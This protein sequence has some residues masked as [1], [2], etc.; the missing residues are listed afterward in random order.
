MIEYR[1]EW[2]DGAAHYA[3]QHHLIHPYN[4]WKSYFRRLTDYLSHHNGNRLEKKVLPACD[5]I[6]VISREMI[7]HFIERIPELDEDKFIYLPNGISDNE[8]TEL[9]RLRGEKKI[10]R[11]KTLRVLY[12]GTLFGSQDIR[13]FLNALDELLDDGIMARD[14]FEVEV[15]GEINPTGERWPERLKKL[16]R[17]RRSVP[18]NTVYREYFNHDLLLFIIGDWPKSDITMTGKIFELIESRQPILA[19]LP[20]N[21]NGCARRLLEK[22]NAAIMAD[23]NNRENIKQALLFL[24]DQ[25]KNNREIRAERRQMDWFYQEHHY[26]NI[27]RRLS[28]TC[29]QNGIDNF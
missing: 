14:D 12:A 3:A 23:I 20:M 26:K 27:Y 22:S 21:K 2:V 19:L 29:C 15:F 28:E 10:L 17:W 18:L 16:V 13:P 11:S 6:I 25:K 24:L 4:R 5:G 8:I 1:D 7:K 9:R